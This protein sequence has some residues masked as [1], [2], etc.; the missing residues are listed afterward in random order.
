METNTDAEM[1]A[2]LAAY[3]HLRVLTPDAIERALAYLED[4]LKAEKPIKR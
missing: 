2:I 1:A 4:R 3:N